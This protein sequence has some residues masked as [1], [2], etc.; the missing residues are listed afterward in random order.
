MLSV[1]GTGDKYIDV[2]TAKL[3]AK[4]IEDYTEVLVDGVSHWVMIDAP[5][6]VNNSIEKYLKDR[7][8]W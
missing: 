1:F 3:S 5:K 4:Y 7:G 2:S 8:L 6:Q